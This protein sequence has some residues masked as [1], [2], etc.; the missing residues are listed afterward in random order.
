[1]IDFRKAME[2]TERYSSTTDVKIE[3]E[4]YSS[5]SDESDAAQEDLDAV[6]E[7]R[8]RRTIDSISEAIRSLYR[9]SVLLRR[10][11]KFSNS[12]SS[13]NST[14]HSHSPL[15]ATLDYAH[16]SERMRSW[17]RLTRQPEVGGDEGHLAT[18][19]KNQSRKEDE[20]QEIAGIAFLYQRFTWANLSRRKQID[21]WTKHPDE[22]E[23]PIRSMKAF[24]K[25]SQQKGKSIAATPTS[26]SVIAESALGDNTEGGQLRTVYAES[27]VGRSNTTRVPDVPKC[28]KN[29]PYFE[30]PFCHVILNSELMQEK[31]IWE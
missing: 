1:M 9:V 17:R 18:D 4:E 28:S 30:C 19:D 7:L 31:K 25:T 26:V 15:R 24:G 6:W 8:F 27:A 23:I 14:M 11:R 2:Q 20:Q 13:S 12:L 5:L 22:P 29:D 21:Y 16:I 10:P 3:D